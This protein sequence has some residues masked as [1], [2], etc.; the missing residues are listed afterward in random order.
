MQTRTF[1]CNLGL[2]T[3]KPVN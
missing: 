3:P 1:A 2:N